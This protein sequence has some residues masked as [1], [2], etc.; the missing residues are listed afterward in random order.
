MDE[1]KVSREIDFNF[2]NP[3]RI[4]SPTWETILYLNF[5]FK[6]DPKCNIESIVS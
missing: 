4:G 5:S 3:L 1:G 6:L 2:N